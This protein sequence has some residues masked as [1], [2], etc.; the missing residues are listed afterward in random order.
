MY[1]T[2]PVVYPV[3]QVQYAQP[4]GYYQYS[5]YPPGYSEGHAVGQ[6]NSGRAN[7]GYGAQQ[8]MTGKRDRLMAAQT[9]P[10]GS[11][12]LLRAQAVEEMKA[13]SSQSVSY[14]EVDVRPECELPES[15]HR[16]VPGGFDIVRRGNLP[17]MRFD[18]PKM[19]DVD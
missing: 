3:Y 2:Q 11:T 6:V 7:D 16:A 4:M 8:M 15:F 19:I 10:P 5:G 13:R 17:S 1:G 18:G 12:G 14:S 9:P